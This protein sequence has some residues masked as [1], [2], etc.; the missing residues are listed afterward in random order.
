MKQRWT[1]PKYNIT[2]YGFEKAAEHSIIIVTMQ[3]SASWIEEE[4][5]IGEVADELRIA[6]F[7]FQV[8]SLQFHMS[9]DNE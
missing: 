8:S 6:G 1:Y 2:G 5:L 3:E 7:Q 4:I 9:R